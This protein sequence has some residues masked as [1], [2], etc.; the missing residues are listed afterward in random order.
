MLSRPFPFGAYP[1]H[2]EPFY[3]TGRAEKDALY[4]ILFEH[5]PRFFLTE[6]AVEK[7]STGS[8]LILHSDS[9]AAGESAKPISEV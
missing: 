4:R 1:H 3:L 5:L 6:A 2:G 7:I 8:T 9:V